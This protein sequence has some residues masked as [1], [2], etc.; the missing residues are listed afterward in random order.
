MLTIGVPALR[1][2]PTCQ[3]RMPDLTL[4]MNRNEDAMSMGVPGGADDPDRW[5]DYDGFISHSHSAAGRLASA[6]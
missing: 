1:M 3:S 4:Q 6:L 2:I 5:M